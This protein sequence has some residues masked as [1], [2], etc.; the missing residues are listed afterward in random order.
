M[1][2]ETEYYDV[3]GVSPMAT[4]A[5][6]KKAY[7][8]KAR[9]VHPDKN[10]NDPLAAQNFQVLGE[11]YQ[12][13]SDPA[14]R[15]A[16]DAYGKSGISTEAIID[17]AAIFAMLFGSELFED[18]IGQL[19]MASMASLDI[20]T[21]GEEFDAKKLQEKMRG[22]QREREEKLA[23][24]LKNRLN[25]YVQGS[26]E[27]FRAHAEAEVSRLSNAAYGVD[28]LNTIGY[29]Y[30]RQAAK[31]LGK[32]AIYL[33]VP[34]IAE[35]FRNKGHFIKSQVTAATGAFALIQLQ[36]DMKRQLS[37]EGNYTEEELE[38]YMQ[39]H[40]KIMIDSLWK[41][42]V[43]DIE[44]TL[45]RVC[46]MVVHEFLCSDCMLLLFLFIVFI[47]ESLGTFQVLQDNNVKKEELRARAKG[48]KTLGKVFQRV[49]SMNGNE[50]ETSANTPIQTLDGSE[51]SY[52]SHS[53]NPSSRS[54][55]ADEAPYTAFAVQRDMP[56]HAVESYPLYEY[57]IHLSFT[58]PSILPRS[59]VSESALREMDPDP[60]N[61]PI[62]SYVMS[63]LP[64]FGS[65]SVTTA[66]ADD[67]ERPTARTR[68]PQ[69]PHFEITDRMPHLTDPNV[70]VA[71]RLAIVD[72]A[73]TRSLLKALGDRPDH[74]MAYEVLLKE[75]E[76]RLGRIYDVAV[77]GGDVAAALE[78]REDHMN[79]G[80][81]GV[82]EEE[83][84]NEEIVAIL[85]ETLEKG[86]ERVD[87]S[88]R[89][90]NLL[91]EAFGR[92]CSLLVLNLSNNDLK[93]IPDS[94]SGLKNLLELYLS[95]NV[96]E[97]LP[98][99]I[100]LLFNLKILDMSSNKLTTLP[101]SICHCRSLVE[102]NV[103]FNKLSYLPTNMGC[104]LVNL[105]R[106]S[107]PFN[108]LRSLPTSIGEMKSLS[109]LDVHFNELHG[110]PLSIGK[111]TNLEILN[112]SS[113]FNGFTHLPDTIGDLINLK[114][115]DLS[116][117]QIYE[118]PVTF[119]RLDNLIEFKMDQNP[120]VV[121][122]KKV[123]DEGVEA[124]KAFMVKKR[125]GMINMAEERRSMLEQKDRSA[126]WLSDVVSSVSGYLAGAEKPEQ[127]DYL[128]QQL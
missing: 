82:K 96:L 76:R 52:D 33:G 93:A 128:N 8:I 119:G 72:V 103:S 99:S 47:L 116:N 50:T 78:G 20:F 60:S 37:A 108:K 125:L 34:F 68:Q 126:S 9:Q 102:L 38:E 40:K 92:I 21:E 28:M 58:L 62:L 2:K 46:Q 19:A 66:S 23:E 53:L 35:W 117:N 94:I 63:K 11:A 54:Q 36:E 6:I 61:F 64:S 105:R 120:V 121:P 118:L 14:Q 83:V 15:Q 31:E 87:L 17:P 73:Q 74:E 95:S 81:G 5:Q 59:T 49:K 79:R 85:Q 10:P 104:E 44:T 69:N 39:S 13:L 12:V 18:Y 71:M 107:V 7:Y 16:Y 4:E 98:N 111:L 3:L 127:D 55:N 25:V 80:S 90:L 113:N 114:E 100:G 124:V 22:V 88:G 51:P 57:Q 56:R 65:L 42:N 41:L 1:V 115:L 27:E 110:L 26:K 89:Q 75:A 91:P 43:A 97:S 32:K 48:L 123:V 122:P 101:D 29:I 106:L 67:M 77:A 45:S 24:I 84:V 70:V 112:L 30:T 109:I 86:V